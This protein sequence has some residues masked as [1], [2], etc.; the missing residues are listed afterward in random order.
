MVSGNRF[1]IY[2]LREAALYGKATGESLS[3]VW[4]T[5]SCSLCHDHRGAAL[6]GMASGVLLSTCSLC[7][8]SNDMARNGNC[9]ISEWAAR[10]VL[11]VI[12][13]TC[14]IHPADR[15]SS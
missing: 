9:T 1:I 3:T 7:A 10:D 5:G 11:M 4:P 13:L 15:L 6:Y 14:W 2:G 8:E 12:A